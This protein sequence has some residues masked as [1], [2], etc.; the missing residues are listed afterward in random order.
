M[1]VYILATIAPYCLLLGYILPYALRVP[2]RTVGELH[3][4][5]PL[6]Y[7]QH[8]R[9]SRVESCSAFS[10]F[11]PSPR[12]V[13]VAIT[14]GLLIA[15]VLLLFLAFRRWVLVFS[16]PLCS[17]GSSACFLSTAIF[18]KVTLSSQY[19]EILRYVESPYGRIVISKEGPQVTF[20]NQGPLSIPMRTL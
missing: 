3:V 19:G 14:S 17:P 9:I 6:H 11:T 13:T 15:A 4:R 12:F 8:R 5:R 1:A 2:E 20:W 7:R 18:E 16:R 10:S